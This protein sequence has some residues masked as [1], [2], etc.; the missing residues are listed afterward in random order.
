MKLE[1]FQS[2]L[3][4][5]TNEIEK[6]KEK[7]FPDKELTISSLE[8]KV[9]EAKE[10][11]LIL[12]EQF[13]FIFP[14]DNDLIENT[15]TVKLNIGGRNL[16]LK[17]SFCDDSVLSFIL[18]PKWSS[19]LIHD[20]DNRIYFDYE[21]RWLEPLLQ[22]LT[23]DDTSSFYDSS[24]ESI[25]LKK[26]YHSSQPFR[27]IL[28]QQILMKISDSNMTIIEKELEQRFQYNVLDGQ[29]KMVFSYPSSEPQ[30]AID[31]FQQEND[32]L[33]LL[34][35]AQNKVYC[36]FTDQS[37]MLNEVLNSGKTFVLCCDDGSIW[38]T[39]N[40]ISESNYCIKKSSSIFPICFFTSKLNNTETV[41][42]PYLQTFENRTKGL[43]IL[44]AYF[45]ANEEKDY[46]YNNCTQ[47][48]G[49]K[50]IEM[51]IYLAP[52]NYKRTF[53]I[54]PS[55][56]ED[57]RDEHQVVFMKQDEV[58]D[59]DIR[60]TFQ[61]WVTLMNQI[62]SLAKCIDSLLKDISEVNLTFQQTTLRLTAYLSSLWS[63]NGMHNDRESEN[64]KQLLE[65]IKSRQKS[66]NSIEH[67]I[68][69]FNVEG[70]RICILKSTLQEMIPNS[71]L[72]IRVASGRW[73]EQAENLDEDGNI[74]VEDI[75]RVVFKKIIEG[76][77]RGKLM[78]VKEII[79][80]VSCDKQKKTI[81]KY[82]DYLAIEDYV[83]KL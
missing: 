40:T 9:V 60:N 58:I 69:Y 81:L 64:L 44:W 3:I 78:K 56:K 21:R 20:K 51:Q 29:I 61:S 37:L 35:T 49:F 34:K 23:N 15:Q 65:L 5:I 63:C 46:Y 30:S 32:C 28:K 36:C 83:F 47:E 24:K 2:R 22:V 17:I 53:S 31:V 41:G 67:A 4:K 57:I 13:A 8:T 38:N 76:I 71:Q 73:E 54:M 50:I 39:H 66:L 62:H 33:I 74:I 72:T 77:R 45:F 43:N 19:Y 55:S 42:H 59:S 70:E 75:P 12:C 6:L 16:D 11:I 79:I 10:Q 52:N 18:H 27:N 26:K 14:T 68:V 25:L 7:E 80:Y 48:E 1:E 82:L